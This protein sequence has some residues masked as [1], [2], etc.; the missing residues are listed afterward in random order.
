MRIG[1][2]VEGDLAGI[3]ADDAT[4]IASDLQRGMAAA[5]GA[6]QADLRNQV[7]AAGL[8]AG[9]EKA[10]ARADYPNANRLQGLSPAGL[11]Y[12]KAVLLHSVF[13]EGATITAKS[14]RYLAIPTREA[15]ALGYASSGQNRGGKGVGSIERRASMVR[16]AIARL[17][18]ENVAILPAKSGRKLVVYKVP[19]GRGAGRSFKV[20]GER[21]V[22]F[23]RG[24]TVPLFILV[25]QVR[26][27]PR[28]DVEAA[29]LRARDRLA[30]ELNAALAGG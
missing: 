28:L 15:E 22:G 21:G 29:R 30:T 2:S 20:R 9:L 23:R 3:L 12:S 13:S 24:A 5:T 1:G 4:A 19:A 14:G 8:G 10:W 16:D 17:G 18:K 27:R 7:R 11:V 25:P 26:L 6:L